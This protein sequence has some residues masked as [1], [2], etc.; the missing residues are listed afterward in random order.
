MGKKDARVDAYIEKSPEFA[1]PIL[2]HLRQ[3]V[4]AACPDA[5]ETIKWSRPHFTLDGRVL[6]FV[7]SANDFDCDAAERYRYVRPLTSGRAVGRH[8]RHASRADRP[9]TRPRV[10]PHRL[11]VRLCVPGR[12]RAAYG[13]ARTPTS[14]QV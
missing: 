1:R 3:V 5:E 7:L 12:S 9:P 11:A 14:L 10:R 13:A 2:K 6:D 8:G 4:H